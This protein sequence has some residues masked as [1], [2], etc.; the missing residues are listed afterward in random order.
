M[1]SPKID[2]RFIPELYRLG[3]ARRQPMTRLVTEAVERYLAEQRVLVETLGDRVKPPSQANQ[4]ERA[5]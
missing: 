5:A 2:E 3:R 4:L 1:Y